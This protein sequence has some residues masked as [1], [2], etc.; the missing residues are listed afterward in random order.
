MSLLPDRIP[1]ALAIDAFGYAETGRDPLAPTWERV[2]PF[3]GVGHTWDHTR[4]EIPDARPMFLLPYVLQ[5]VINRQKG[6]WAT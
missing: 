3:R 6:G 5:H 4:A 2:A 1:F